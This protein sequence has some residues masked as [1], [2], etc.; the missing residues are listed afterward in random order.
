LFLPEDSSETNSAG[1]L[2]GD[3]RRVNFKDT[4]GSYKADFVAYKNHYRPA[5]AITIIGC[6]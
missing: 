3:G 6:T 1:R 5:A 4:A 2:A